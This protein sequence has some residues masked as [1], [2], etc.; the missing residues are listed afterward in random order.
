VLASGVESI[1]G[2]SVGLLQKN[3]D[4]LLKVKFDD[5][6]TFLK[7]RL[8]DKYIVRLFFSQTSL[9]EPDKKF[10]SVTLRK[11]RKRMTMHSRKTAFEKT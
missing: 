10:I 9:S 4:A 11:L 2:F 1:F 7:N 8:F 6:L 5:I 3:E